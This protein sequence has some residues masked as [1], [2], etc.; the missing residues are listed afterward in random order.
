MNEANGFRRL[1]IL[2]IAACMSTTV[3]A[4]L[5]TGTV[6]GAVTDPTGA[7]IPSAHVHLVDS[8]KGYSFATETDGTGRYLF[9]SVPP[10]VYRISVEAQGFQIQE[11]SG[12][13]IDVNQ[14]VAINFAMKVGAT[15]E[16]VEITAAAPVLST[17]DAVTGQ[18]VDRKFI[19]DL[20]LV[21]RSISDLA[22]LTPGVTEVDNA[23]QGCTANN[24]V[25]NGTV[26]LRPTY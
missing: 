17:Q 14:N 26:T 21:S 13:A 12:I 18:L 25:S 6:T 24:F 19:N 3:W 10:G 22:Y 9:R 23:C 8:Q 20:P 7:I 5:Y 16:T 15:T 2:S 4:Q 11:E 1:I